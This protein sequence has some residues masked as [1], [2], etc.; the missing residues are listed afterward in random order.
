[1]AEQ[2]T[3]T[4]PQVLAAVMGSIPVSSTKPNMICIC[5]PQGKRHES[6]QSAKSGAENP[7]QIKS[8][9]CY[10][11]EMSGSI[12]PAADQNRTVT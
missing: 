11:C 10:K 6:R 4:P 12:S 8:G 5:N 7:K 9:N 3:K 2:L 1:M